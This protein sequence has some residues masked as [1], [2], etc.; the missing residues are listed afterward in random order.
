[1]AKTFQV[2]IVSAEQQIFSGAA[3]M[4]IA[5]GEAGE[6]GVAELLM[7]RGCRGEVP[8]TVDD[9]AALPGRSCAAAFS[10][11]WST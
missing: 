9:H 5:P 8:V 3:E 6:L 4:V 7:R 1:M 11:S 10:G 2:D